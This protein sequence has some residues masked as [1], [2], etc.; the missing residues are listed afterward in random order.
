MSFV[1]PVKH[2]KGLYRPILGP[3]HPECGSAYDIKAI[4]VKWS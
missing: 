1:W 3:R 2:P 4:S